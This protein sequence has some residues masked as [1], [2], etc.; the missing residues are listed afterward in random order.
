MTE[1]TIGEIGKKV[2][3]MLLAGET[4]ELRRLRTQYEAAETTVERS[5]TG[6][7]SILM[8]RIPLN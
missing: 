7:L 8:F 4:D 6:F 3:E 2:V 5:A 1:Y